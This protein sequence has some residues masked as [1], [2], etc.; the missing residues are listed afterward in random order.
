MERHIMLYLLLPSLYIACGDDKDISE[1]TSEPSGDTA[2]EPSTEPSTEPSAETST[3]PSQ[4]PST[5]QV[6]NDTDGFNSNEGSVVQ[7][8]CNDGFMEC[9]RTK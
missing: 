7:I 5:E 1:P 6:D 3:E 2:L 9:K 8:E 4:E